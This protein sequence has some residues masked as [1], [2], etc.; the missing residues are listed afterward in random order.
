MPKRFGF[1]EFKL[2]SKI[3]IRN[4]RFTVHP[5]NNHGPNTVINGSI[6]D[7]PMRVETSHHKLIENHS[8]SFL[9]TCEEF[10]KRSSMCDVVVLVENERFAVHKLVLSAFCEY[11]QELFTKNNNSADEH[12]E[13]F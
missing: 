13:V 8:Q 6:S 10:W 3:P 4:K 2:S 5:T 7:E 1:K 11:F 12:V 9:K